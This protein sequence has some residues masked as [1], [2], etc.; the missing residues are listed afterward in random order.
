M[1]TKLSMRSNMRNQYGP[2]GAS[3]YEAGQQDHIAIYANFPNGDEFD[4]INSSYLKLVSGNPNVANLAKE[5][6][7]TSTG[8]GKT[9]VTA[10]YTFLGQTLQL[11]F[12]VSVS[13]PRV[14]L[15]LNPLSLDFGDQPVGSWSN[16]LEVVLT[17]RSSST[18]K[19]YAP[20]IRAAA[21]ESDD[22][23]ASPLP[24]GGSCTM[25][26][27]FLV[28]QAG[29]SQGIIYIPNSQSGLISLPVFGNGI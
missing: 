28:V 10:T 19:I 24:P 22:C 12:P 23:T 29:R 11:S 20:E 5:G 7:L 2:P 15:I 13:V 17:N 27:T 9:T 3:F 25:S 26:V 14:G 6:W 1:P 16:P 8:P 18:I 4:V 21:R